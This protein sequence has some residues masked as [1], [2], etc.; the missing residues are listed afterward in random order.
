MYAA[1]LNGVRLA[2]VLAAFKSMDRDGSGAPP[3]RRG[4][5]PSACR[6]SYRGTGS[7]A[8]E[9][10]LADFAE[11]YDASKHPDVVAAGSPED[12]ERVGRRVRR[13]RRWAARRVPADGQRLCQP[14][15]PSLRWQVLVDFLAWF[16]GE[17]RE[18]GSDDGVVSFEVSTASRGFA[19]PWTPRAAM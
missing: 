11:R 18:S 12:K 14:P 13:S 7:A 4:R 16:R 5:L 3:A 9:I 1:S 2:A 19:P 6:V 15:S 10:T 8:G 17:E